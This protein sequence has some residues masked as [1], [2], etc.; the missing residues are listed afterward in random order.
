MTLRIEERAEEVGFRPERDI[1][2]SSSIN[3]VHHRPFNIAVGRAPTV[4][5]DS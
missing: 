2:R 1:Y 4:G 5:L 3:I